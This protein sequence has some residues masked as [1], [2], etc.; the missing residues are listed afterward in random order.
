MKR[1]ISAMVALVT[2]AC[3]ASGTSVQV[4]VPSANGLSIDSP[5][6]FRGTEIG[7]IE[8]IVR[9]RAGARLEIL[10][11]P[12]APVRAADRVAVRPEG[13]FGASFVDIIPGPD[14]APM[15]GA[16]ATLI[17]SPQDSMAAARDAIARAAGRALLDTLRAD[18]AHQRP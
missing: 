16:H 15:I 7:H 18:L 3:T 1:T 9:T 5:V 11:A 2:A 12:K 4:E 8:A 14:S 6:R 17:A 13:I 10:L